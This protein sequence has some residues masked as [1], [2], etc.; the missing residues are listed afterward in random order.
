[1]EWN[2]PSD[3]AV[4]GRMRK[5]WRGFESIMEGMRPESEGGVPRNDR[6]DRPLPGVEPRACSCCGRRFKP[7]TRRRLLCAGCFTLGDNRCEF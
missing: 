6:L 7:T 3:P 1:M 5:Q 2:L 4:L